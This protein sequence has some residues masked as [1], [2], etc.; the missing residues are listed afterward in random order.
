[1]PVDLSLTGRVALVTGGSRGIG[2]A[3]VRMFVS[4]GARVFFNYEKAADAAERLCNECGASLCAAQACSLDSPD[5]G[6]QLVEGC[7]RKF[8]GL[9]IFVA[10]HGIWPA[11][12]IPV[13]RMADEHWRKTLAVNLDSVF[14][15]V[16]HAVAQMKKSA[17]KKSGGHIVLI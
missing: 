17:G 13:D 12:D 14:G 3:I 4:A 11:D 9:D 2:A 7:V 8:G 16:K 1:M 10:N 6:K 15:L 5:A